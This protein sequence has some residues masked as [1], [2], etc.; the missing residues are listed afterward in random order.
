MAR[1]VYAGLV[2]T[3]LSLFL[4]GCAVKSYDTT[5]RADSDP[6]SDV[7]YAQGWIVQSQNRSGYTVNFAVREDKDLWEDVT[8]GLSIT[9]ASNQPVTVDIE[10]VT[11]QKDG[12]RIDILSFNQMKQ[13]YVSTAQARQT[14]IALG[15]L[16]QSLRASMPQTTTSFNSG[17]VYGTDG[18]IT[19]YSG[20]TQSITSSSSDSAAAQAQIQGNARSAME[21]VNSNLQSNLDSLGG[22]FQKTTIFP[23]ETYSGYFRPGQS[24]YQEKPETSYTFYVRVG[25]QRF[26][27]KFVEE[28]DVRTTQRNLF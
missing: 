18:S 19:S 4:S 27:F 13:S 21:N 11:F 8:A 9:N 1:V 22:Y 10:D 15:A 7:Y 24:R 6:K 16:S 20:T 28:L 12:S 23:G 26:S 3:M 25:A 17:S 14:V 5:F 2:A